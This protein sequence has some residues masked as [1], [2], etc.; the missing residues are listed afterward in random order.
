M[1]QF[2]T[3]DVTN[4]IGQWVDA[5]N[6]NAL[7]S[8]DHTWYLGEMLYNGILYTGLESIG[9]IKIASLT[10][11]AIS[12]MSPQNIE[13]EAQTYAIG[14]YKKCG[15]IPYGNKFIMDGIE[16]IKMKLDM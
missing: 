9:G 13:I 2:Q 3:I 15:F 11:T 5:F 10:N 4:T 7:A 14:F 6:N 8:S 16:H 1:R 12:H